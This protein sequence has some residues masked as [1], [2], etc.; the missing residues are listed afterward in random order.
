MKANILVVEDESIVAQDLQFTLEDLG[1][2]VSAIANS[3][4]S[5]IRKVAEYQPDLILMDIRI[6]GEMDGVSTA[7]IVLQRFDLPVVFLTAHADEETLARAKLAAPYGYIIKPFEESELHTTI[8]IA[9]YKHQQEQQLKRNVQWL[10]T[11]ISS[12]GDGIITADKQGRIT[13][14][15][16][17]AEN[18]TRLSFKQALGKKAAEILTLTDASTRKI[19]DNPVKQVL[20]NKDVFHLPSNT[21]LVKDDGE[22]IYLNGTVSPILDYQNVASSNKYN[23]ELA[24]TVMI[25]QDV[26]EKKLAAQNLHRRAFYDSLTNLPNRA[27]FRERLT[28]AVIRVERNH[29]YLFAVLFL[30]LDNFKK[31]NDCLGH[32]AGDCLLVAVAERLSRVLRSFDTIARFGGDEF[33]IILESLNYA[34]ESFKVARRIQKEFSIPFVIDGNTISA[35]SSIGI[36]LSSQNKSIDD[37]IRDADIAMY[38]AKEQGGGRY[39]VFDTQMHRQVIDAFQLENELQ[40]AIS[41]DQL[42][43]Y[44]QPIVSLSNFTVLAF[45]ALVRWQH[46]KKGLVP[47]DEFIPFAEEAGLVT[48]VDLWVLKEV[49]KQL[50]V[51]EKIGHYSDSLSVSVNFSSRHFIKP[52]LIEK[53]SAILAETEIEPRKI[54]LEITETALI[55]N[56][57]SAVEL[58]SKLRSLG[59]A[60]SLD[61]FGT[62]YS[63]LSYL[64]QFPLNV[65]KIDR[66]FV[67]EVDR[68]SKNATITRALIKIA[69]QLKLT[70]IAEG[71]ETE[72][73]LAFLSRNDCDHVQGYF[74]SPPLPINKLAQLQ[75]PQITI[76]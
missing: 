3:G 24:G 48:Q 4:E 49:C 20:K 31:V 56:R 38:R 13:F 42:I 33:G 21:I 50:K 7:E 68:N 62:G 64:Q 74:F 5:A 12:I 23:S 16:P 52:D 57:T 69:H 44:Y 36:V 10:K 17:A 25:F 40:M 65:L 19:I 15:N 59:V 46:P 43:V 47:P 72:E 2:G 27:W 1:Y 26:T 51:W 54:K 73:E 63:S 6:I 8:E 55:E 71:V 61:D 70:V 58:L 28:D 75:M 22:E 14:L 41:K 11:V 76:D 66:C 53:V 32:P 39:A 9:L 34:N 18:L 35:S 60:L 37:L 45:E 29:N 67:R 30:D